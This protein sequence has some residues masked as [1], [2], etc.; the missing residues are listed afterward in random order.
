MSVAVWRTRAFRV[1]DSRELP[2]S[3]L[4]WCSSSRAMMPVTVGAANEVPLTGFGWPP[5]PSE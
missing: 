2:S 4:F 3:R 5:S 1:E